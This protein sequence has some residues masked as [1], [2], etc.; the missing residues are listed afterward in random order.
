M[1]CFGAS[2]TYDTRNS[3]ELANKGQ[4][5]QLAGTLS[6]GDPEFI[7]GSDR[8][9]VLVLFRGFAPEHVLEISGKAGVMASINGNDVPFYDQFYVGGQ[10]SLARL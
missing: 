9:I 10:D 5:T 6:V 1:S 2:I 8:E 3:Y 7:T 4:E